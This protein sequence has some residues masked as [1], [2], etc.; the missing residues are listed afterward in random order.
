MN[1]RVASVAAVLVNLAILNAFGAAVM[2][3]VTNF[4][5]RLVHLH[6]VRQHANQSTLQPVSRSAIHPNAQ[7]CVPQTIVPMA[8][9]LVARRSVR[10]QIA[11]RH[12]S[13]SVKAIAVI[14]NVHGSA[15]QTPSANNL[16]VFSNVVVPSNACSGTSTQS[17]RHSGVI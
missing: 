17:H 13:S 2:P 11:T 4:A 8:I 1:E 3:F 9:V 14:R 10:L 12:A 16:S 5:N 15:T 7:S 6:N